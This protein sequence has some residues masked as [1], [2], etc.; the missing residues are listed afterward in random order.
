MRAA[1]SR[2]SVAAEA[3]S[4]NS[5]HARGCR[6]P[7]GSRRAAARSA[8]SRSPARRVG[9]GHRA[10]RA[11]RRA[12]AAALAQVRIDLHLLADRDDRLGRARVDAAR[13]APLAAASV[14]ADLGV[15]IE[16][17]RLL[18]LAAHLR[19]AS[20]AV[21]RARP[22]PAPARSSRAAASPAA[23]AAAC[24]GPRP[25]RSARPAA[26]SIAPSGWLLPAGDQRDLEI[27][28][29][30]TDHRP[31][32]ADD[33]RCRRPGPRR[34]PHRPVRRRRIRGL[35]RRPR[36]RSSAGASAPITRH[37]PCDTN[38]TTATS[39]RHPRGAAPPARVARARPSGSS[40]GRPVIGIFFRS[41]VAGSAVSPR[42]AGCLRPSSRA[43]RRRRPR[44]SAARLGSS[45]DRRARLRVFGR[46]SSLA[47]ARRGGACRRSRRR[48]AARKLR[49]VVAIGRRGRRRR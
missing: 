42:H 47:A 10:A 25:G 2:S 4:W 20:R 11:G 36:T 24:P 1:R 14:R 15:V 8:L 18:E 22:R 13:A 40:S 27:A 17:L 30:A 46:Q 31:A 33:Q 29:C 38:S 49:E 16:V 12:G 32:A 23:A 5:R 43:L 48:P 3:A 9:V 45:L 7:R 19:A 34:V 39:A 6:P 44:R 35:P 28:Q 37:R 21:R 41:S 26:T